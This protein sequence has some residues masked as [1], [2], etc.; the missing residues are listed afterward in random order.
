[1]RDE[2]ARDVWRGDW[3]LIQALVHSQ[4]R[5]RKS[6]SDGRGGGKRG[7]KEGETRVRGGRER[8]E[9]EVQNTWMETSAGVEF[10]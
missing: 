3:G 1:L 10:I 8:A 7:E 4:G 9:E 6:E 2:G 5:K